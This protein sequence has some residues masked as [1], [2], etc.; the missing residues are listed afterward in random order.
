MA[1]LDK[2]SRRSFKAL[3]AIGIDTYKNL[4]LKRKELYLSN[5]LSLAENQE[6]LE[7]PEMTQEEKNELNMQSAQAALGDNPTKEEMDAVVAY[8][9]EQH[10]KNF[11]Q[12]YL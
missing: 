2:E 10:R 5:H 11:P 12:L 7:E 9:L 4:S 6:K 8:G 1:E 3:V